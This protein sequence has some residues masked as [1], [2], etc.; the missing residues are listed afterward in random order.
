MTISTKLLYVH[1]DCDLYTSTKTVLNLIRDKLTAWEFN[2]VF[3]D[4][5]H[6]RGNKNKGERLAFKEFLQ[7]NKNIKM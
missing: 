4:W 5:F 6:F 1:I 2:L 3:D 7:E